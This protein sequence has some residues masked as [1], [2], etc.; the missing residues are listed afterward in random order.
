M[1]SSLCGLSS[2]RSHLYMSNAFVS[3]LVGHATLSSSPKIGAATDSF[4]RQ[5][6]MKV[7]SNLTVAIFDGDIQWR[8]PIRVLRLQRSHV[9]SGVDQEL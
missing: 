3:V 9:A 4:V 8:L 6:V 7:H 1:C 2:F 5:D